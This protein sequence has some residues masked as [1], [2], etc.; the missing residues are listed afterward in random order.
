MEDVGKKIRNSVLSLKKI[1]RELRNKLD[2][3]I[4]YV[5]LQDFIF[6]II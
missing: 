1:Y 2:I 3:E 6:R 5:Q 4:E